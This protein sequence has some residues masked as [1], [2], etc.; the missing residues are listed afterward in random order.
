MGAIK[1]KILLQLFF[2]LVWLL[3]L[4]EASSNQFLDS[5]DFKHGIAFYHDLRYPADFKNFDYV[6]PEAPKGGSWVVPTQANFNSLSP[7][8]EFGIVAP[9]AYWITHD[10]LLERS[11]DESSAFYGRLAD[12]IALTADRKTVVFRIHPDARWHDGVPITSR[13]IA[14]S[15]DF[16]KS[17]IEGQM[18]YS[19]IDRIEEIS[20]RHV[21]MHLRKPITSGDI[22]TLQ[23][24]P[25]LPAHYWSKHNPKSVTMEVPIGSGPYRIRI[26]EQGRFIEYER[27]ADYWG[28][29]LPTVRGRY[30]FDVIRYE[31]YRDATVIREALRKGLIDAW[32]EQDYRYWHSAYEIPALRKG[33]LKKIQRN[34]GMEIGIQHIIT[35]NLRKAKFRDRRVRQALSLAMDFDW[36]NKTLQFGYGTR[37]ESYWPD[38]EL[39]AVGLPSADEISLVSDYRDLIPTEFFTKAF[40][41][42]EVLTEGQHRAKMV[43]ARRLLEE[44]GFNVQKGVL[45]G[46]DGEP[47][48]LEFIS[49]NSEEKRLLLPYFKHLGH[50]GIK[51]SVR[52]MDSSQYINRLRQFEYDAMVRD[53]TFI[54]PPI[55]E[56]KSFFHTDSAKDPFSRN[57]G[58]ISHP[59]VDV[60]VDKAITAVT[61]REVV[62]ACRALDRLL[63]WEHFQIPLDA[64]A[65]PRTVHWDKFGRPDVEPKIWPPFPDGWWYD[66]AKARRI[67]LLN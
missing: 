64:V 65:R 26:A 18:F 37:A 24:T 39:T 43:E 9:D 60:L 46:E 30:N 54:A 41:F 34:H 4:N 6:N 36:W 55:L 14:F 62:A 42:T 58:G 63:L 12:G 50:L 38:T 49:Q 20:A 59:V 10:R 13:D 47:F 52:L 21:A 44:A 67:D 66:P 7:S 29:D 23:W 1:T 2:G 25:I 28:R 22:I 57:P 8:G 11:G 48:E 35:F 16:R 45:Y 40:R 17:D 15:I 27:V 61:M 31:V 19:F 5:L 51:A 32:T 53:S 56:L 3:Q 33:L